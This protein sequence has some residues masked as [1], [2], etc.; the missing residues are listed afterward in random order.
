MQAFRYTYQ[1]RAT[2]Q[3]LELWQFIRIDG[4]PF[5]RFP[6]ILCYCITYLII[7]D[8]LGTSY[9]HIFNHKTPIYTKK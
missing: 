8:D 6:E 3:N 4:R 7:R 9:V 1:K 5:Q 2:A